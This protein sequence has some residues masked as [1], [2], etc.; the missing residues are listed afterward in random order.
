M[1]GLTPFHDSVVDVVKRS[2]VG[3]FGEVESANSTA[4][5]GED[6]GD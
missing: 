1:L 4:F 6:K 3:D 5:A 2:D